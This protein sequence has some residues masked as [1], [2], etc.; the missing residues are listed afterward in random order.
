M[1]R[2][3][4]IAALAALATTGADAADDPTE[5]YWLT[6]NGKAIVQTR[7]CGPK[8]CGHMVWIADPLDEDGAAKLGANGK[9]L[10]GV[11]LLG[12][13]DPDGGGKWADGW[14]LDPRS[15]DRFS[16]DVAVLSGARLEVRGY[17]GFRLLG[18]S[19]VWTRVP[20]DRGGC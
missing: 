15:G 16:V 9:P 3:F 2:G 5:G 17:L 12:G 10:C 14:I 4:L 20:D 7:V 18:S 13:L 11:Q 1:L 6:E 8:L 19:Q